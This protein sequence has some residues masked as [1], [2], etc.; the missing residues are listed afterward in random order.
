MFNV[1]W[2]GWK[3]TLSVLSA[4]KMCKEILKFIALNASSQNW[5]LTLLS[6]FFKAYQKYLS[7][8][9]ANHQ[10]NKSKPESHFICIKF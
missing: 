7:A 6:S 9:N 5:K 4:R 1:L 3:I 2:N 8:K 10:K